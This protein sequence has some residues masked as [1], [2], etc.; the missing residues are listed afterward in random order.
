MKVRLYMAD[1]TTKERRFKSNIFDYLIT[2]E[3]WYGKENA[4]LL[5]S[6]EINDSGKR[7]P[8]TFL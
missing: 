5:D 4:H 1:G 8:I 6:F 3:K 7:Y 2:L